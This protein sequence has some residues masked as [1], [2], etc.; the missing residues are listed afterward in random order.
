MLS[1][2]LKNLENVILN[3]EPINLQTIFRSRLYYVYIVARLPIWVFLVWH[4]KCLHMFW[5]ILS[6]KG[7]YPGIHVGITKHWKYF[8]FLFFPHLI[9]LMKL[10]KFGLFALSHHGLGTRWKTSTSFT[11]GVGAVLMKFSVCK[12]LFDRVVSGIYWLLAWLCRCIMWLKISF[13]KD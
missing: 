13:W 4:L 8:H 10:M 5:Y 7:V 9:K 11:R 1:A 12:W 6:F 3:Y 2:V